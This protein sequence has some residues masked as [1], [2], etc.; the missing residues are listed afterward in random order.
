MLLLATL[1]AVLVKRDPVSWA[2][3][4]L[5]WFVIFA[6]CVGPIIEKLSLGYAPARQAPYAFMFCQGSMMIAFWA[7]YYA[8]KKPLP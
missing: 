5:V 1:F 8:L 2:G 4:R 7:I 3:V 6:A